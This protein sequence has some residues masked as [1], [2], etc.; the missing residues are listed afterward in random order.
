MSSWFGQRA[1]R[2]VLVSLSSFAD[3]VGS[4]LYVLLA[5]LLG[6][7]AVVAIA[8]G[9]TAGMRNQAYDLI[10]KWR[11]RAPAPDP[12]IVIL[13]IDEASLA[14]MAGEYGRWPWP[15]QIMGEMV[16]GIAAQKPL[17]IVFDIAFSDPDV[18]NPESDKYF[19]QVIGRHPNTYFPIIR[20][21][22]EADASSELRL[23]QLPGVARG[24]DAEADAR[25]AAVVPF[26]L[27]A[28][29]GP[30]LGTS[31]LI[32]DAD[33]ILRSYPVRLDEYGW[34][35]PSLPAAV[36]AGL[37]S[38]LPDSAEVL[39]NWRGR[40]PS[41]ARVPFHDV[42]A[43]LLRQNKQR[44]GDEFAGKIVIIGSTAPSLF[45]YKA[46]SVARVHPGV[47]IL[48]TAVDNL[49]NG[50]YLRRLPDTLAIVLTLAA[51]A[52][53]AVVFVYQ[54]D[55]RLVNLAFTVVQS[56]FLAVSYLLL[57]FS[58]LF[59]DLT[60]PFAFSLVYFTVAR[61]GGTLV[62]Y[63]RSGHPLFS[64]VLEPGRSCRV[65]FVQAGLHV[66]RRNSRLRLIGDIK[67]ELGRA[68]LGVVTPPLFKGIP[69]L[70]A[71]FRDRL[72]FYWLVPESRAREALA[73]VIGSLERAA[74]AIERARRTYLRREDS[75]VTLRV[76]GAGLPIDAN[77]EWVNRGEEMLARLYALRAPA[78]APAGNGVRIVA[79]DEFR[80]YCRE[81][82]VLTAPEAL[83][84]AGLVIERRK[85]PRKKPDA[86]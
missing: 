36:V 10:M 9:Y 21:D 58:T 3:R 61:L 81:F 73:D 42:Y 78:D 59:V 15:R 56:S 46:T 50:D 77:E 1:L 48:A 74:R 69:L 67:K 76:H 23:A 30:R 17:A 34:G 25:V 38:G 4:R 86:T 2:A 24:E 68:R 26:F 53:L 32:S 72:L 65:V 47:E 63:R 29:K 55:A 64:D 54:V 27:D 22:P 6:L 20:L 18:F 80:D 79:S 16:E 82:E 84:A 33:G 85:K 31:N 52:G 28:V 75:T 14:A 51:L 11:L 19:R 45:D 37:G 43:D 40:P 39:L 83:A 44:A 49:R 60:V 13:D 7:I 5:A 12:G 70:H 62:S 71:F 57:N 35:V 41:Y 8:G 66:R